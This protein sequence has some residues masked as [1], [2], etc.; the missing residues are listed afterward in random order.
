VVSPSAKA[1]NLEYVVGTATILIAIVVGAYKTS[2]IRSAS[3]ERLSQGRHLLKQIIE[4]IPDPVFVRDRDRELVLSN[5]AGRQFE[6]A[7]GYDLRAVAD[8]EDL[9]LLGGHSL[10]ADAEVHA[11]G[12][13]MAVSVKTA[14]SN[15]PGREAM[16]VTVMRDVTERRNLEQSLRQKVRELEEARER[17]RQLEGMLPIC[18]HCSRIRVSGPGRAADGTKDGEKD[19]TEAH[20]ETLESYVSANSNT[21]FTHTLCSNCL[22]RHYPS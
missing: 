6:N 17:V 2:I 8:Q 4:A 13:Q 18:M 21:S 12:G 19:G 1:L 5:E 3:R 16:L 10:E 9:A 14:V 22:E 11:R 7:T 15:L 20:W